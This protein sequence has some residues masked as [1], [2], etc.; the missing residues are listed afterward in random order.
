MHARCD[1]SS[2]DPRE[3]ARLVRSSVTAMAVSSSVFDEV[4]AWHPALASGVSR[5]ASATSSRPTAGV[6]RS[7]P[8]HPGP[9]R[10]PNGTGETV[11]RERNDNARATRW[12]AE[13]TALRQR[14]A[15]RS[16]TA[17]TWTAAAPTPGSATP[18]SRPAPRVGPPRSQP[19]PSTAGQRPG[20]CLAAMRQYPAV[21]AGTP[22]G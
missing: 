9:G 18:R 16:L 11:A 6:Q 10:S 15:G 20:L 3:V 12:L 8:R 1:T 14:G 7:H 2:S 21:L 4:L 13:F 5:S 22:S 17:P 19:L